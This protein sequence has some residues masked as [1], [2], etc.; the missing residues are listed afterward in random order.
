MIQ[1]RKESSD[2][3]NII[4]T[5]WVGKSELKYLSTISSLG[6][7]AY[8][9]GAPQGL[10]N[11]IFEYM[12]FGLPILSSLQTETKDFLSK[13]EIGLTYFPNDN[14]DLL[15]KILMIL[16]D[17]KIFSNMKNNSKEVFNKYYSSSIVY[18]QLA[19]FIEN[20]LT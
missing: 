17:E 2:L 15:K 3:N 5:G 9:Q 20:N 13:Y 19:N 18:N 16:D 11:K 10:P 6:L 7:M 14:D 8:S 1:W 12:A 4:F